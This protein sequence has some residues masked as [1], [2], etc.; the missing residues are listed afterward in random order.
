MSC[1]ALGLRDLKSTKEGGLAFRA[2]FRS[3]FGSLNNTLSI[4]IG[5]CSHIFRIEAQFLLF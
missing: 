5:K 4:E 3:R 1:E 2:P